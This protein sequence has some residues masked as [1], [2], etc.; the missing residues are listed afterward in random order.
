MPTDPIVW[1]TGGTISIHFPR[2]PG[3]HVAKRGFEPSVE[4]DAIPPEASGVDAIAFEFVS[5]IV[6]VGFFASVFEEEAAVPDEGVGEVAQHGA[7]VENILSAAF[8]RN[9]AAFGVNARAT[10]REMP[11]LSASR[12]FLRRGVRRPSGRS[13][14]S[15]GWWA[16]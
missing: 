15:R 14:P 9:P 5:E 16:G 10:K 7:V 2:K 4:L 3:F 11:C 6:V 13:G 12:P 8:A 1:Y